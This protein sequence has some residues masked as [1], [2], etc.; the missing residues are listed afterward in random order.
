MKESPQY[1][2]RIYEGSNIRLL[3]VS[4]W[5]Y[6][7]IAGPGV[8]SALGWQLFQKIALSEKI[9]EANFGFYVA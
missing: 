4:N 8:N 2:T 6:H 3:W 1:S 7:A 5:C 9:E